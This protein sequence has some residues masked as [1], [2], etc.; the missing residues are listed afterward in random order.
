[1]NRVVQHIPDFVETRDDSRRSGEFTTLEELFS[2]PFV[3]GWATEP[4]FLKWSKS[5]NCLMAEFSPSEEE[6][7]GQHW[8]V[9]FLKDP[10]SVDLPEWIETPMQRARREAWNDGADSFL[11]EGKKY[12]V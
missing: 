10:S 11:W 3:S 7:A 8:V 2:V 4:N 1:M 6:P 12:P 5:D 9:G